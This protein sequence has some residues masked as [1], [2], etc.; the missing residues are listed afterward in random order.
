[1]PIRAVPAPAALS[2][3]LLY[4]AAATP[5]RA[6]ETAL[7][8]AMDVS[9]SV[10]A[11]EYRIQRDGLAAALRD[12]V[13][14][15]TLASGSSAVAVMQWSGARM[16][17]LS[18][19]WRR[20]LT[21]ADAAALAAEV[22]AMPRAHVGGNTALGVALQAA[23]EQFAAVP[24]CGRRIVDVSGDGTENADGSPRAARRA[25]ERAGITVNA[26]AIESLGRALTGYYAAAVITRDGFVETAAGF[27][28]F[29]RAIR[30]KIRR[31]ISRMT[32]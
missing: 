16:Q 22:A 18:V 8:L 25:A 10:D 13:I 4:A 21:P 23:L 6:C 19:P 17:T 2:A 1:M 20:I 32:G 12:P 28:D 30:E 24:D 5:A 7:L 11:G 14:A 29:A 26:L 9:N 15:E 31:E 3:L 27:T